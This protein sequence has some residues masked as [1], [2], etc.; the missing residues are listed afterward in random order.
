MVERR[1]RSVVTLFCEVPFAE[2]SDVELSG[3]PVQHARAR[4]I[5]RGDAVRLLDGQGQVGEGRVGT[6]GKDRLVVSVDHLARMPRPESLGV[7]VPV[8]DKERMLL[9]AEKC[10]ELQVTSWQPVYF[11]RSRSVS[12][13]GEGDKFRE[14]VRA[15]MRSALE[16]SGGAWMPSV[17]EECEAA[18]ALRNTPATEHRILLDVSGEPLPTLAASVPTVL[19]VGP[20][21]GLEPSE[22]AIAAESGWSLASIGTTTL[23]FE[24]AILAAAAVV[25]ASQHTKRSS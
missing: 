22:L 4:R 10:V 15:R 9:A 2:G 25:R 19:A 3:D 11:A 7:I 20:E 17:M 5:D 12:P 18:D 6:L 13:R 8:A 1:D 23:R 21:G 24:T 16:Q 14:K